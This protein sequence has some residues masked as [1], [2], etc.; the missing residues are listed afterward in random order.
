[1]RP[2]TGEPDSPS[3]V[4]ER[5]VQARR[6]DRRPHVGEHEGFH[7]ADHPRKKFVRTD[8]GDPFFHFHPGMVQGEADPLRGF[9]QDGSRL[10]NPACFFHRPQFLDDPVGRE[11]YHDHAKHQ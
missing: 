9:G 11:E 1:M 4:R 8:H 6:G 5:N 3:A 10:Q 2:A 7:R